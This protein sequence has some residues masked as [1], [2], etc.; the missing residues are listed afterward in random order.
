MNSDWRIVPL[1]E[2][3]EIFDGPHATPAKVAQGPIFLGI[4]N[5]ARGRL[6]LAQTEHL[7]EADF[8]KW[9]RRVT[10]NAG[11]VVFSYETR[12][13]EAAIIP[14]GLRCCLGRR[15]GLLRPRAGRV[16]GRF[17]LYAY[18]GPEFQNLLRA[19]TIHGST[20]DRIPLID[21]PRFSIRI[22]ALPEQRAIAAILGALDDKIDLNRRMNET[23][24]AMARA[25]FK[26]WF[27]DFDPVRAKMEGRAPAGMDAETAALFPSRM[28]PSE[29]GE[30]PEGWQLLPLSAAAELNPSRIIPRGAL[31]PYV[32]M[33]ALPTTGH[34]ATRWPLRE[35]GS[36]ARF[37]NGDTLFARITPCL[38][39]G[40]TGYVDFLEDGEVGSGSTEYIVIRPRPPLPTAWGY[41]LARDPEFRSFAE[42][43]MEGTTGRQRVSSDAVGR[44]TVAMPDPGVG[45][46]AIR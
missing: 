29:L 42:Q 46:W 21:M 43:K 31:A 34:R 10:P 25:I 39:N 7:S 26:S 9:T 6:N 3:V 17:L 38:E 12:L 20:V 4:S 11:D 16:D 41:L 14:E 30:V 19:R 15:M 32:E 2:I 37:T 35:V 28:V 18:L 5:L 22:P 40:K 33:A 45:S 27:V 13:G 23:L 1:E 24:E 44:Y 8:A 36:G